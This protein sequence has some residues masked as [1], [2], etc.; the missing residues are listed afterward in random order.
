[1]F[2]RKVDYT[3]RITLPS[4]LC[5]KFNLNKDDMVEV[6]HDEKHILIK[7]H[8]PEYV[9]T[10]T[11]E[12]SSDGQYIGNAYVSKEG[13]KKIKEVLKEDLIL[14]KPALD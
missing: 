13:L 10:I 14:K 1:M 5:K 2:L 7:R 3:G 6:S 8:Y 9:C 4:E 12:L 11:G